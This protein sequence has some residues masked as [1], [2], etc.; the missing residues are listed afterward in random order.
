MKTILVNDLAKVESSNV[1]LI[2][3]SNNNRLYVQF[4]NGGLYQYTNVMNEDYE[5]LKKAESVGKFLN[6]QIKPNYEFEK[7]E[8]VTLEL[9]NNKDPNS[10]EAELNLLR[11]QN[12]DLFQALR[13]KQER[14]DE[15]E[16]KLSGKL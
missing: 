10:L 12:A 3:F 8:D 11:K 9:E 5:A 15:L 13:I 16:E 2:G 14:I 7:L 6:T 4:K 1:N